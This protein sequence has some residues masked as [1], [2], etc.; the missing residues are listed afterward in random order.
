VNAIFISAEASSAWTVLYPEYAVMVPEPQQ[1][2]TMALLLP[3]GDPDFRE[4]VAEWIKLKKTDKTVERLH[5]KWILGKDEESK[6]PRWSIYTRIDHS[7]RLGSCRA[8]PCRK[9]YPASASSM[10]GA[11]PLPGRRQ[12]V[13]G[14]GPATSSTTVAMRMLRR[15]WA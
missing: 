2:A 6:K 8:M 5:E 10:P 1:K 7:F 14:G 4:V 3:K 9:G 11:P 12:A 13:P 15:S